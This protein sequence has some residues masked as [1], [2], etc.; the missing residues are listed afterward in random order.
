MKKEKS[1]RE[2]RV[3]LA[4][5]GLDGHSV[6]IRVMARAL[7]DQGF[8]V[9]FIGIR[10]RNEVI[11]NAAIQENVDVI[12]LSMLSGAHIGIMRD[13]MVKLE[14]SGI[15]PVIVIGGVIPEGDYK[16]LYEIGVDEIFST[17]HSFEEIRDF[18]KERVH[19]KGNA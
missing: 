16:A 17:R 7:R 19:K 5:P 9:V 1:E 8:E 6:G 2:I 3:L 15:K 10:Q 4:K 11:I 14:K 18:I 13:F 12:G